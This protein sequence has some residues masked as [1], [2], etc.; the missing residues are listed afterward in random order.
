MTLTDV[1]P[2][3]QQAAAPALE[4]DFF[5]FQSRLT[6]EEQDAAVRIREFFRR[7]VRPIADSF[8][9][10]AEFPYE[11]IRPLAAQG[12]MG[13]FVPEVRQFENSAVYRGWVAM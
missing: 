13:A 5:G 8:W 7:E 9:A 4:A 1:T 3:E 10:R 6:P 12:V 11:I 2:V